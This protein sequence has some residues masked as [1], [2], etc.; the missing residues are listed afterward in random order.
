MNF[1][2]CKHRRRF[3]APGGVLRW[4]AAEPYRV[5][6]ALGTL[7]SVVGVMLWPLFYQ[8]FLAT[9]P[10]L[11]HARLMVEGFGGAFV[12]GFL[13][14]AGPRMASAPKLSP[15]ELVWLVALHTACAVSHLRLRHTLGDALFALL[16]V[17]LMICLI[18]RVLRFREERPPPQL[19]LALTGLLCGAAGA[20]MLALPQI[21]AEARL[22]RLAFLLLYQGLL[23][24]PV[25]G[26][27]SF[28]FP[29]ILGGG[30]GETVAPSGARRKRRRAVAAAV[31]LT[32]SFF[33]EAYFSQVA[34]CLLRAAVCLAYLLLEVAW[35]RGPGHG[36]LAAGLKVALFTGFAGLV[37]AAFA[38]PLQRASVDHLL[39]I[40]GF[41][42]LMLVVASRVLFGH[43]GHLAEF[44]GKSWTARVLVGLALIAATT[45]AIPALAPQV[46]VTHHQYAALTWAILAILWLVWHRR[47]F[48][49]RDA[50]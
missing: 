4:L 10:F 34:G 7:W 40:G 20:A 30:F 25:L 26:I 28:I 33:L 43:S 29:R 38:N 41:G 13:G 50:E 5:F 18:V 44:A 23:L 37:L 35:P 11:C 42:L 32:A 14:T 19:L 22:Y 2:A 36:T 1:P 17:S 39:Y 8:G 27:G 21:F 49:E 31:L 9:Y 12:V 16:L 6:F 3:V 46:A 15:L 24:P 48:L 45:R 47:R